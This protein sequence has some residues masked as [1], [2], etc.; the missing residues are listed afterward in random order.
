MAPSM[1]RRRFLRL[2]LVVLGLLAW[3]VRA[4]A[5]LAAPTEVEGGPGRLRIGEAPPPVQAERIAGTDAVSLSLLR[6]RVVVIDFWATWCRPCRSIMP[7][8]DALHRRL[9]D[10]G[11]TILGLTR[12]RRSAI[13]AHLSRAPV[14]YTVARDVGDTQL[15]YGVSAL[16]TLVVLDRRGRVRDVRIGG[17]DIASLGGLVERLL[18]EPAP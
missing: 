3:D 14:A 7:A 17:G 11:L 16:P 4:P 6:G 9:H 18:A 12:E 15:L 10:Q 13:E 5:A 1:H 2:G 8:L